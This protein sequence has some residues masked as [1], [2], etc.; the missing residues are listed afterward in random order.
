MNY[1]H[2]FS[3]NIHGRNTIVTQLLKLFVRGA[4]KSTFLNP[5]LDGTL[6]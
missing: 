2:K 3:L 5:I 6:L 4:G 1:L